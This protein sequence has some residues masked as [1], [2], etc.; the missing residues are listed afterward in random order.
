MK[1]RV[2]QCK[3]ESKTTQKGN[4]SNAKRK[5]EQCEEESLVVSRGEPNNVR[6]RTK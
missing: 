6:R 4:P 1:R 5:I 3:E 2:E